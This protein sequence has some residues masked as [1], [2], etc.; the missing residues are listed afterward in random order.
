MEQVYSIDGIRR[1]IV[2]EKKGEKFIIRDGAVELEAAVRR[3]SENE[4]EVK[5]EG[6]SRTVW[7][8]GDGRRRFMNALGRLFIVAEPAPE[9][10][11]FAG[12]DDK[13][14]GGGSAVRAPMP[15]RV[16]QINVSEGQEV[17]KHQSLLIVE[18][19]K[20]ENDIRSSGDGVVKKIHVSAGELV[21]SEKTLVELELKKREVSQ[22]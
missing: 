20:M 14:G 2:L 6:L 18:A 5:A 15:G 7:L 12:G 19:M 1:T 3:I 17:R 22:G 4:I 8:A 13:T 21:D 11:A 16:I 10:I 9:S